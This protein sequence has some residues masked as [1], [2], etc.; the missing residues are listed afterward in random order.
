M[1]PNIQFHEVGEPVDASLNKTES[2]AE[3]VVGE[4][5]KFATGAGGGTRVVVVVTVGAE[6]ENEPK[7]AEIITK[8]L[9]PSS[10]TIS[11]LSGI[12]LHVEGL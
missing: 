9:V 1:S 10:N 5:V 4:P 2:G 6:D 11:T 3:P 12:A 8:E 7:N